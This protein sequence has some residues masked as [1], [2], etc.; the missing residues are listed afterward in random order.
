MYLILQLTF[1]ISK[2]YD[3]KKPNDVFNI[4]KNKIKHKN[5][6]YSARR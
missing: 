1:S 4:I 3:I 6:N 5:R 2:Q